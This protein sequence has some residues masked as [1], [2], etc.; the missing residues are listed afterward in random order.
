[1]LFSH[2]TFLFCQVTK[3][4]SDINPLHH[5]LSMLSEKNGSLQADK[6]LLEE[7]VKHWKVKAQVSLVCQVCSCS[8]FWLFLFNLFILK[9]VC[10]RVSS[11]PWFYFMVTFIHSWGPTVAAFLEIY[12]QRLSSRFMRSHL[13]CKCHDH[14]LSQETDGFSSF[15][16]SIYV[17]LCVS[18]ATDEPTKRWKCGGKTETDGRKRSPAETHHAA[19]WRDR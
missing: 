19:H 7:D 18:A 13:L 6:R 1:M 11:L 5:S 4:Q 3:L 15:L 2:L 16:Y 14:T 8:F 10:F 9:L 12:R 17:F